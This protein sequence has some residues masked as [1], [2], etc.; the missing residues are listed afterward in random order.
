VAVEGGLAG[1][2][3]CGPV[4]VGTVVSVVDGDVWRAERWPAGVGGPNPDCPDDAGA[5]LLAPGVVVDKFGRVIGA[6]VLVV[7]SPDVAVAGRTQS[8]PYAGSSDCVYAE[9]GRWVGSEVQ[10]GRN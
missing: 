4:V 8:P 7:A 3:D 2:D 5:P 10:N 1:T 6:V 9:S